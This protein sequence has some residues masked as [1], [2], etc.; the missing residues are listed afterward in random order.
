MVKRAGNDEAEVILQS[1]FTA[2]GVSN[3]EVKNTISD[4]YLAG[5]CIN[6]TI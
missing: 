6:Y 2:V 3:Y 4:I 5:I 1:I